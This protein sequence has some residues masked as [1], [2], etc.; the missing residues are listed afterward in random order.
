MLNGIDPRGPKDLD[1]KAI[2]Q[3]NDQL[4]EEI[5][6]LQ[7]LLYA[8]QKHS[9][10]IVLQG[11]DA[12]GKDG[13]IRSIF[14]AVNPLGCKVHAFKKPTEEEFGHDFLWR[15]HKRVPQKGMIHIFNRSHYEDILVPSVEGYFSKETINARFDHINNFERLLEDG[16][17]KILKFYLHISKHEQLE[18]LT[19][20]LEN[21]EKHWKHNDGDWE[22]RKKWES[23]MNVYEEI[24]KRCNEVPWHIVPSDRNWVK[25]NY[26]A[27]VLLDTLKGLNSK[28]PGLETE[29]FKK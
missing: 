6:R 27:N 28:W 10:L 18:R 29:R 12:A 20:R 15:V 24:F 25:V 5:A 19:E 11:L 3:V 4:I 23:Y 22:S 8:E 17:T 2:K 1:K 16:G 13:A 7:R 14:S 9:V 21:P 26:I